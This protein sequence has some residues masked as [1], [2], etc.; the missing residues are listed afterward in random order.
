MSLSVVLLLAACI[1]MDRQ[2]PE[3]AADPFF[4][5]PDGWELPAGHGARAAEA[6]AAACLTCHQDTTQQAT[7]CGD[8]HPAYPHTGT[9]HQG[10][11]H[12]KPLLDRPQDLQNCN[13]CH[14]SEDR[15]AYQKAACT[16]CHAKHS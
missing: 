14:G 5:H 9:W 16:S 13:K 2:A 7:P 1:S 4:P 10:S 12:G 8:C 3:P 6:G 15:V 11:E